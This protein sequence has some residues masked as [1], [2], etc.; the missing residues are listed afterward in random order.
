M[1]IAG[2]QKVS[3]IDFPGR[4]AATVFLAGCNLNCGYCYNR[5]MIAEGAV[6]E[7]LSALDFLNWLRTRIGKL[8]G[9]CISGGEPL[10]HSELPTLIRSIRE[11]GYAIKLDTNGT[12]PQRLAG[13]LD[14]DLLDYVA[15]DLKAPMDQRFNQIV[16]CTLD[17]SVIRESMALL[18]NTNIT[19]EFRTTV[20][21][22]LSMEDLNAL[23]QELKPHESWFLQPF[24]PV[25]TVGEAWRTL[26]T[27]SV[28]EIIRF[29]VEVRTHLPHVQVRGETFG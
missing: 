6:T 15:M 13:L 11:M 5:W 12:W 26:P 24:K 22:G 7:A 19:Y 28:P 8:D 25:E 3:L 21:P 10:L 18:R 20:C 4:I 23:A 29:A 1:K 16:G 27:M 2:L 9:V 17:A 14:E